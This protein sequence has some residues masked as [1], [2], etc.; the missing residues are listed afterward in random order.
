MAKFPRSNRKAFQ[1][2]KGQ[3]EESFFDG[4]QFHFAL[5][6]NWEVWGMVHENRW[7]RLAIAETKKQA[8][9]YITKRRR[10][11]KNRGW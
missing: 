7:G 10:A 6:C 11:M 8:R 5:G 4:G 1:I 2:Q 3:G 9:Q